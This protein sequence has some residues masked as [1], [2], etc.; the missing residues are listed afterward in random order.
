MKVSGNTFP[1]PLP[2][3]I[4][5]AYFAGSQAEPVAWLPPSGYN[6]ME[7]AALTSRLGVWTVK[8]T[9][10]AQNPIALPQRDNTTTGRD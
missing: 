5:R 6:L 4:L 8:R 1:S 3:V 9:G 10:V 2:V 7:E